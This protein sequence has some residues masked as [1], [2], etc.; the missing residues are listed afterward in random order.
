MR[1]SLV[2]SACAGFLLANAQSFDMA[3]IA[4]IADAVSTPTIPVVYKIDPAAAAVT[5]AISTYD[6]ASALA[7]ASAA[8]TLPASVAIPIKR[9]LTTVASKATC[10]PQ[11]TGI[12]HRSSPDLPRVFKADP[13]Y[14]NIAN[15]ADT[16]SGYVKTFTNLNASN[17]AYGKSLPRYGPTICSQFK[18]I[19]DTPFF[20]V[21][22]SNAAL[23]VVTQ[24]QDAC[25]STSVSCFPVNLSSGDETNKKQISSAIL[26]STR[27]A[28][29]ALTL[30]V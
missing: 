23:P 3:A 27:T 1:S 22:M 2:S 19:W 13:Y 17:N 4:A 10:V 29:A 8:A 14:A 30:R 25:L 7:I 18:D 28:L 16:P 24:S 26:A 11:P 5:S 12:S 6:A 15:A 21:T 9:G 20:Q